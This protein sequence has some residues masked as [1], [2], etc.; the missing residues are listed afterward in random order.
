MD[1]KSI[2]LVQLEKIARLQ[3]TIAEAA[4]ILGVAEETLRLRIQKNKKVRD[5]WERGRGSGKMSLRRLQWKAAE[6]GQ[7]TMLVWLGKQY[8]EQSDKTETKVSGGIEVETLS[9][10]TVKK[11]A[12]EAIK[13]A[14]R[15]DK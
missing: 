11:I 8:L 10:E 4:A 7:P 2:D 9:P 14:G 15:Q 13:S 3:P 12:E 1:I 6:A 5:V